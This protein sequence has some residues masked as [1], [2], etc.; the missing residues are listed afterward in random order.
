MFSLSLSL[1]L[2]SSSFGFEGVAS[3]LGPQGTPSVC[4]VLE[5]VRATTGTTPLYL[6]LSLPLLVSLF[7]SVSLSR[8]HSSF[9]LAQPSGYTA[10]KPACSARGPK[11]YMLWYLGYFKEP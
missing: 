11:P 6:S 3:P 7:L 9:R 5:A 2:S 1:S 4:G 8:L 10:R